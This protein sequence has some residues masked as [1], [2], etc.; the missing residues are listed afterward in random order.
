MKI[1][2]D[3]M[4]TLDLTTC[5]YSNIIESRKKKDNNNISGPIFQLVGIVSTLVDRVP[6]NFFLVHV[7]FCFL[8]HKSCILIRASYDSRE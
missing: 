5:V 3:S 4:Q 8:G 2:Q 1:N 7:A 6:N